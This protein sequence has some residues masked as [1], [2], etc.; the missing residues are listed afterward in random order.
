MKAVLEPFMKNMSWKDLVEYCGPPVAVQ[1]VHDST[2]P[3]YVYLELDGEGKGYV[4]VVGDTA[5]FGIKESELTWDQVAAACDA[6]VGTSDKYMFDDIRFPE[7]GL[8]VYFDYHSM[9]P[10][11]FLDTH[12]VKDA[13]NRFEQ[14]LSGNPFTVS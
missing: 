9:S 10:A 12:E 8:T 5:D 6:V 2:L 7:F 4:T 11:E 1:L 13:L 3:I 14:F